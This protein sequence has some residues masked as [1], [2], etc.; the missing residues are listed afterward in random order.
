MMRKK[1]HLFKHTLELH[2]MLTISCNLKN[3]IVTFNN[4]PKKGYHHTSAWPK[5][6]SHVM[7]ASPNTQ[8]LCKFFDWPNLFPLN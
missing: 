7:C 1:A 3:K 4:N 8:S 6:K 5:Q 2:E